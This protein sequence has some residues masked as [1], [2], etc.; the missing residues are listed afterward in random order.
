M[1]RASRWGGGGVVNEM[2]L[3]MIFYENE[4]NFCC[5]VPHHLFEMS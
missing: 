3:D 2:K 4:S 5:S 1:G